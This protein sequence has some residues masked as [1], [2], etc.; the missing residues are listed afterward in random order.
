[1]RLWDR[2]FYIDNNKIHFEASIDMANKQIKHLQEGK[3]D[4]DAANIKQLNEVESNVTNYL[5]KNYYDKTTVDSLIDDAITNQKHL[6]KIDLL[7]LKYFPDD[8]S[9]L[10]NL[11][12][13]TKS[14]TGTIYILFSIIFLIQ[15]IILLT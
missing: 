12:N 3:E 6:F 10:P 7:K 8:I 11:I 1:M 4:N 9:V 2:Y 5:I 14:S 13:K 15:M